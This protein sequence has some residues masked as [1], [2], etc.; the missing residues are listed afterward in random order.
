MAEAIIYP[1][2]ND[3]DLESLKETL[4]KR[5]IEYSVS[6]TGISEGYCSMVVIDGHFYHNSATLLRHLDNIAI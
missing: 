3:E 4:E 6:P 1:G 5:E 2:M